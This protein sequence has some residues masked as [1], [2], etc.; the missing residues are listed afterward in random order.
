MLS[1]QGWRLLQDPDSLCA[2]VLKARYFPYCHVL[3]AEPKEGISYSWR[4]ILQGLELI[5]HGY[6]WRIG[7][8]TGV[9]IWTDPWIPRAWSRKV[10]T[11]RGASLM[12]HVSELICPITGRWDERLVTDTFCS[13]DARR[14]LQ[15]PLREGVE[16]F[17]AWHYDGK[18][19]HSVRSAYR[20]Q[21]QRNKQGSKQ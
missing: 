21:T 13:E 11:P 15:I 9:K 1:R 17:V 3:E 18:G 2:R 5:K 4:S 6:I 16:D 8:G 20:V 10:I 19:V 7:D 14:I 12:T